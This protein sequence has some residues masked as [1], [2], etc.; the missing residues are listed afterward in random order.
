MSNAKIIGTGAYLPENS[1]HN[2]T[3]TKRVDTTDEWIQSRVGIVSR[4]LAA[5]HETTSYM[6]TK[7]AEAA[8]LD[9]NLSAE[10]IDLIIVGTSTP[11]HFMPSTATEVQANLNIKGC[12][13]F[14][15]SAACAGFIYA[16]SV[17]NQYF[18]NDT[19]NH[20]LIIGADRMS[21]LLDWDDRA[22]CV[23]FGDGAGA[24]V[25]QKS[26]DQTGIRSTHIHADGSKKDLLFAP[27]TLTSHPESPEFSRD[28]LKMQG[29]RV[30][31]AA[32]N[33]LVVCIEDILNQHQLSADDIDW[34]IPHQ[35][36]KRIIDAAAQKVGIR[37]DKVIVTLTTHG[38]TS[39]ASVPLALD[40]AH[41]DGR[42][43]PGD[44]VLLEAFGA[45]FVWG[46]ILIQY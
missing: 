14:D 3:L 25:L 5:E 45:G 37:A 22:T 32:V 43:K 27:S 24:V 36:N 44:L 29:P 2:N 28:F 16:L 46:G 23:L 8:L 35:A 17:G 30:M 26:Q 12:P 13:A 40:V 41:R 39:A 34:V 4:H 42:I 18:H 6:A 11:D 15:V 19:I 33:K 31:K 9:A 20:A 7:A 1:V 10:D 21:R 38:N